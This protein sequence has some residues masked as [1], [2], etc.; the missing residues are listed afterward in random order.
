MGKAEQ[1]AADDLY[2]QYLETNQPDEMINPT[3]SEKDDEK[4]IG[5]IRE[6]SPRKV[7]EQLRMNLK[8][9]EFDPEKSKWVKVLEP[10]MNERGINKFLWIVKSAGVTEL[11][12]FSNYKP[13]DI[14]R[15]VSFI[16]HQT[17]PVIYIYHKEYGLEKS[18]LKIISS[19]IFNWTEAAFNKAMGAG[20]R[21][22]INK[23][24][25]E[26]IM[27]R[28]GFNMQPQQESKGIWSKINP[29]SRK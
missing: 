23:T 18:D 7:I 27:T 5:I 10:L 1:E 24:I 22:V 9:Y 8:G 6:L 11:L 13:D 12:T 25:S 26:N 19:L 20:D 17:I 14:S 29:F 28:A 4:E 15:R 16:C 2:D 3:P 21:G